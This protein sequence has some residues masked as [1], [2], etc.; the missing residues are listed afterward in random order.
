MIGR[1][2]IGYPW[3]LTKKNIFLKQNDH[4]AKPTVVDR[5]EAVRTWPGQWNGK[6]SG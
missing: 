4:L 1:S 5:V 6:V 3:S 2:A